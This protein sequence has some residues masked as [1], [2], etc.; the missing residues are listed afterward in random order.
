MDHTTLFAR[1][2]STTNTISTGSP[3][4]ARSAR[5]GSCFAFLYSCAQ[6][7]LVGVKYSAHGNHCF[8]VTDAEVPSL[9][10]VLSSRDYA[11]STATIA[12]YSIRIRFLFNHESTSGYIG[13]FHGFKQ[14]VPEIS[15]SC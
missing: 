5:L 3:S 15:W 9:E 12:Y 10:Q 11:Y 2:C 7:T 13:L 14:K 1:P 6:T 8:V 4:P